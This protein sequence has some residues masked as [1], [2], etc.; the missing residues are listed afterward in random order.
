MVNPSKQCKRLRRKINTVYV[1][2]TFTVNASARKF[3][4][5]VKKLF[6]G[7]PGSPPRTR[8]K[9]FFQVGLIKENLS[10]ELPLKLREGI[11]LRT[12][13]RNN[14]KNKQKKYMK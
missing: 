6:S 3:R 12:D 14:F 5:S 9:H 13:C 11:D 10:F 4:N 7:H 1:T 8:N 2:Y